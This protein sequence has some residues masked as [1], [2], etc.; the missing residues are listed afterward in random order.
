MFLA[1]YMH[2]IMSV[3]LCGKLST[4]QLRSG[5]Q[6]IKEQYQKHI[7]DLPKVQIMVVFG[8]TYKIK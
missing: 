3:S 5:L 6:G 4:I 1:A 8:L 7:F 2:S